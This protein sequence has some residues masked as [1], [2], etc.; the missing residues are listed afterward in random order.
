MIRKNGAR[1]L[2]TRELALIRRLVASGHSN[3]D[4]AEMVGRTE[5]SV[6]GITD[7][8]K[9]TRSPLPRKE[10]KPQIIRWIKEDRLSPQEMSARTGISRSTLTRWINEMSPS[11]RQEHKLNMRRRQGGR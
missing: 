2:T 1:L 5:Q 9:M 11:I 3:K 6:R 7:Y 4:I 8:H 10:L